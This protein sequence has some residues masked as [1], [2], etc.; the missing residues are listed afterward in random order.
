MK[1]LIFDHLFI[2]PASSCYKDFMESMRQLKDVSII[3][4]NHKIIRTYHECEGRIEKLSRGS[5][6]GIRR[7]AK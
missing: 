3:P 2:F 6:F 7:L 1:G 4:I 5:P